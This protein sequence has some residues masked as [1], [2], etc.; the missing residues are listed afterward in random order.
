MRKSI[1]DENLRKNLSFHELVN[2]EGKRE[3]NGKKKL[4]E[5]NIHFAKKY[6]YKQIVYLY[7]RR[8]LYLSQCY[9]SFFSVGYI[10][11]C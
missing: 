3:Q 8:M 2:S 1:V 9:V 5:E 6:I 7:E 4:L 11:V 10:Y